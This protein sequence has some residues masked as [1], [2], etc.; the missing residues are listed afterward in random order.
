MHDYRDI[1]FEPVDKI[2]A[3]PKQ[4]LCMNIDDNPSKWGAISHFNSFSPDQINSYITRGIFN[5]IFMDIKFLR[6]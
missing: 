2:T 4:Q 3:A 5:S 1:K 6:I